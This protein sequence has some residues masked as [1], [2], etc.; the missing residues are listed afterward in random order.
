MPCCTPASDKATQSNQGPDQL[1]ASVTQLTQHMTPD[2]HG[3]ACLAGQ[4]LTIAASTLP[5]TDY[6]KA[7]LVCRKAAAAFAKPLCATSRHDA[8]CCCT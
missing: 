7:C 3:A 1:P 6:L 8:R 2:Q 4:Q 5:V